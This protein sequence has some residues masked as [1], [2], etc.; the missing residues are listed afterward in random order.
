MDALYPLTEGNPFYIEETLKSMQMAGELQ[1]SE[2][3]IWLAGARSLHYLH[4]P[5]SVQAAVQQRSAQLSTE[6]RG[7]L[8]RLRLPDDALTLTCCIA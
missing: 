8:T 4:I 2:D 5:R 7:L 1:I 6:A 3:G